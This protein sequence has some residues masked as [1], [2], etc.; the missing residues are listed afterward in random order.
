MDGPGVFGMFADYSVFHP[1]KKSPLNSSSL[2]F[3]EEAKAHSDSSNMSH[4]G[5]MSEPES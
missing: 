1:E 4:T 3:I 2:H 5:Q